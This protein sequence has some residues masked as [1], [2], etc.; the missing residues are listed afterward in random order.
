MSWYLWVQE[1]VEEGHKA[2][3]EGPVRKKQL[4]QAKI[5]VDKSI[6]IP[7]KYCDGDWYSYLKQLSRDLFVYTSKDQRAGISAK[8]IEEIANLKK[9]GK[10]ITKKML[11]E[12][13]SPIIEYT[14]EKKTIIKQKKFMLG[15]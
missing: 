12:T 6:F 15:K 13:L 3:F 14:D 11:S 10:R 1:K 7:K 9:N 2:H 5:L 4:R 8:N